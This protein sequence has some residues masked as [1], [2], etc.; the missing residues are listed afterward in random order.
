MGTVHLTRTT[1]S[2]TFEASGEPA[3]EKIW[4]ILV[5]ASSGGTL[6]FRAVAD[7]YLSSN[8]WLQVTRT[9]GA[10]NAVNITAGSGDVV[11]LTPAV[12]SQ[13]FNTTV[14]TDSYR[15][16]GL[17]IAESLN[18]NTDLYLGSTTDVWTNIIIEGASGLV[19][20]GPNFKTNGTTNHLGAVDIDDTT[21]S[22]SVSTGSLQTD[23]GLGVTLD[24]FFGGDI[25][26]A[27]ILSVDDVTNS[28]TTTTGSIHTDG[29]LG[30]VLDAFFGGKVTL[31]SGILDID[32]TT[33][34]TTVLTGSIQTLGGAGIAKNLNVG[35]DVKIDGSLE[36][37]GDA[38]IDVAPSSTTSLNVALATTAKSSLRMA[39]GT[40]PTSPVNGD[41]WTTS[42][43]L[44]VEINGST[45]GPLS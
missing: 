33:E 24:S 14:T 32:D 21:N 5:S 36:T 23:G 8:T 40:A 16:D 43:G 42:A 29:G 35:G 15:I 13:S 25:T 27:N 6:S 10:L 31:T 30:V 12:E 44:F 22:T 38:G 34:S 1:P 2:L 4:D 37:V 26:V 39:H 7:D 9:G 17:T 3:D 11:T 45:V 20:V 18:T 28:T 19:V 41:M